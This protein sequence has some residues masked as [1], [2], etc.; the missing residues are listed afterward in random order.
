M[1]D[2]KKLLVWQ[3]AHEL[4]LLVYRL[5]KKF[6]KEERFNLIDQMRRS[7]T[8]VPT[9]IAEGCGKYTQKDFAAY[10]QVSQGSTQEIEYLSILSRDLKYITLEEY[11]DL[12]SRINQVKAMLI[13]LIQ[14]V[15]REN[16][17]T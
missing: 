7:A 13:G 16:K 14:K 15:R 1:K 8:S 17:L 4:V 5:T 6:P 11:D 3:K 9:N 2:F 12:N 10:L